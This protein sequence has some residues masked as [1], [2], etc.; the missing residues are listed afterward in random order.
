[1]RLTK[2]RFGRLLRL[3][4]VAGILSGCA[5]DRRQQGLEWVEGQAAERRRLEAQGFPQFTGAD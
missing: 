3:A 2:R 4:L 1:M 5:G